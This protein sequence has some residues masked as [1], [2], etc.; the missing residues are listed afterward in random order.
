[1]SLRSENINCE[2]IQAFVS[3]WWKTI[4]RKIGKMTIC[5]SPFLAYFLRI[6]AF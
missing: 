1:M 4:R 6:K 5:K 3:H 2:K